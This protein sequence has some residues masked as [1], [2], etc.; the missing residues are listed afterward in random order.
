MIGK[1]GLS[2]CTTVMTSSIDCQNS[3]VPYKK[4]YVLHFS[5]TLC[6]CRIIQSLPV[7]PKNQRL[8]DTVLKHPYWLLIVN[9]VYT[10]IL[11]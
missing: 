6:Y 1:P 4:S 5:P 7:S 9:V 10:I 8:Y 11:I 3:T 2:V